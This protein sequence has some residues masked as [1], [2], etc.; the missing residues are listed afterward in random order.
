MYAVN[1]SQCFSYCNKEKSY[2]YNHQE[3]CMNFSNV[4]QYLN[5]KCLAHRLQCNF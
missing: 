2:A 5:K 1:Y 3:M 4:L